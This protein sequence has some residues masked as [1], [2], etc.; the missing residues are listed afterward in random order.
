[1]VTSEIQE[2]I[3]IHDEFEQEIEEDGESYY[4]PPFDLTKIRVETRNRTIS[5]ILERI[6]HGELD[7]QPDFQRRSGIWTVIAKSRL[8][9]SILIRI[10]LPSFYIDASDDNQWLIV[11]GLQRLSSLKEFILDQNFKLIGL[12]Y[13]RE[14]EN[15][16]YA[17]LPRMLQR[18]ILETEIIINSIEAGTPSDIKF[19]IFR[20]INTGGLPLSPQ[21]IRR[22][23][24]RGK[25]T[26]LLT[27]LSDS[28]LF[29]K[30]TQMTKGLRD[31]R[32]DE[33]FI[34]RFLAFFIN[35]YIN[36]NSNSLDNLLNYT[37]D[38][39]NK[40][41]DIDIDLYEHKFKNALKSSYEIFGE[42]AFRKRSQYKRKTKFP[43]NKALFEVWLVNL[44]H[45]KI[46]EI[47]LLIKRKDILEQKFIE[48][49]DYIGQDIGKQTKSN[50]FIK[51]IS[52]GTGQISRVK[53]R[54]ECIKDL[55]Q[56]IIR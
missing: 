17:D 10:P 49:V 51:A 55:I 25:A 38:N 44:A 22:V 54:F 13:L 15:K 9:E 35:P 46:E 31:R 43:L 3:D 21:E 36:Y 40:S 23:L 39:L 11:D 24:Y 5:L 56:E 47:E 12:E 52:Q 32:E 14:F 1:M 42:F 18:R 27:K 19:Y 20:R 37:M 7:L 33:E 50:L 2:T 16:N 45:L 6:S 26:E 53:Y 34:L 8:I 4:E 29:K 41:T 30:T 48:L 28:D